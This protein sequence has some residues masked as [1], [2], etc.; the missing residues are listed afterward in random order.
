MHALEILAQGVAYFLGATA[1]L[2]FL[3]VL[4]VCAVFVSAMGR[5]KGEGQ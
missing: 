2:A 5:R 4:I 3:V 1:I